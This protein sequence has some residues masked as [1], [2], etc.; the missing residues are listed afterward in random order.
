MTEVLHDAD[1]L[2]AYADPPAELRATTFGKIYEDYATDRAILHEKERQRYDPNAADLHIVSQAK[3][4]RMHR[5]TLA[6]AAMYLYEACSDAQAFTGHIASAIRGYEDPR[7]DDTVIFDG[8]VMPPSLYETTPSPIES[9][10]VTAEN[11][12]IAQEFA[13]AGEHVLTGLVISGANAWGAFYATRGVHPKL[14]E[15]NPRNRSDLDLLAI[16]PEVDD[17]G[18]TLAQYVSAGLIKETELERFD[19]FRRLQ[20]LGLADVFSLRSHYKGLEQSVHFLTHEVAHAITTIHSLHQREHS[21]QNI[22]YIRDYRPNIPNNPGKNGGGYTIDDL[23]GLYIGKPFDP[24]PE[25]SHLGYISES[26]VGS[27]LTIEGQKT[28]SLGVLDFFLAI[29]PDIVYDPEK[30]AEAWVRTLQETIAHIQ[31]PEKP[32][33][34]PR[35]IRMPKGTL[36]YIEHSLSLARDE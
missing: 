10:V 20:R 29:K 30:K 22:N 24:R 17:I 34:I 13:H 31:G 2:T 4:V 6:E 12:Y 9:C 14:E 26:P 23:K 28:Y 8:F 27:V 7:D 35:M 1:P 18:K 16:I 32:K 3:V 19:E 25:V 15:P 33:N 11:K 36:R 5:E 21:G